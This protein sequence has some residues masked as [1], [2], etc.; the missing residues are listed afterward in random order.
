MK[1]RGT[2]AE[3]TSGAGVENGISNANALYK[4]TWSSSQ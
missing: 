4:Q 3:D 2:D 1:E